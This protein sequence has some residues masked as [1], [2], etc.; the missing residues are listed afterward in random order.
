[1]S[2]LKIIQ[3]IRNQPKSKIN[4]EPVKCLASIAPQYLGVIAKTT[5]QGIAVKNVSK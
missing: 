2:C 4:T 1:M 3:V 5:I